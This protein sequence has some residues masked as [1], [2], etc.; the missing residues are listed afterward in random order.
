MGT[1]RWEKENESRRAR[2]AA[3]NIAVLRE[4]KAEL[5]LAETQAHLMTLKRARTI[6]EAELAQLKAGAAT[7]AGDRAGE[8]DE[9]L[10]RRRADTDSDQA[11][12]RS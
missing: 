12:T 2:T 9:L 6:Q 1:L 5:A 11:G 4:Q 10:L 8:A 7:E 3:H